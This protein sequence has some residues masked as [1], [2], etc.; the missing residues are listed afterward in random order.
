MLRQQM[1]EAMRIRKISQL[2]REREIAGDPVGASAGDHAFFSFGF[3]IAR[4]NRHQ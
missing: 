4:Y 2:E 1:L 3:P